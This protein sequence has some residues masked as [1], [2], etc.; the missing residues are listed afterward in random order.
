LDICPRRRKGRANFGKL[1]EF[2]DLAGNCIRIIRIL[3]C[4]GRDVLGDL[5]TER[6]ILQNNVSLFR[7]GCTISPGKLV[8]FVIGTEIEKGRWITITGPNNAFPIEE[9]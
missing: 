5:R 9:N 3:E 7:S 2:S 8:I 4:A 6:C 1:T